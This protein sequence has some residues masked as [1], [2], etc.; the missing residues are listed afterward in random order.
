MCFSWTSPAPSTGP[1][2]SWSIPATRYKL[3]AKQ[4]PAWCLQGPAVAQVPMRTTGDWVAG[5]G[6]HGGA[7]PCH[8]LYFWPKCNSAVLQQ[9]YLTMWGQSHPHGV[10]MEGSD[11]CL[12]SWKW[13]ILLVLGRN[14][15]SV[16]KKVSLIQRDKKHAIKSSAFF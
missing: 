4:N 1:L 6:Y 13:P 15:Q 10:K 2:H 16:K 5:W 11:M 3:G 9:N 12:D 8:E 14:F 7:S